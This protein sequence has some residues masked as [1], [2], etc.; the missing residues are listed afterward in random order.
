MVSDWTVAEE[1]AIIP[2]GAEEIQAI[3][4]IFK[5]DE[6]SSNNEKGKEYIQD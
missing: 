3:R 5:K 6:N 1:S 4:Q 2:V